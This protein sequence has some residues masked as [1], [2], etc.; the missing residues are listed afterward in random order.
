MIEGGWCGVRETVASFCPPVERKTGLADT[1]G[2]PVVFVGTEKRERER[3]EHL[4]P[5]AKGT[6]FVG[7]VC[8]K[9]G[10]KRMIRC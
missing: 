2:L 3:M 10:W 7:C 1:I 8:D 9:V 5:L 6:A 4:C